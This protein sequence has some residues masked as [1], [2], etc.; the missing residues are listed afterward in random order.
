MKLPILSG[1]MAML[2]MTACASCTTTDDDPIT[3]NPA[4]NPTPGTQTGNNGSVLVAY[5]SCTGTT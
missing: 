5:F 4:P 1:L 3:E 2:S